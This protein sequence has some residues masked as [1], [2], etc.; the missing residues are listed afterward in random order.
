MNKTFRWLLPLVLSLGIL[1][2]PAHAA[3]PDPEVLRLREQ[4]WRAWFAGDEAALLA[5]L[6]ADFLGLDMSGT[7]LVDRATAIAAARAF[8]AGGGRLVSLEFP[9][10]QQ[11][12]YGDVVVFYGRFR[13]VMVP[14]GTATER[15][16]EG[17]LTE[18]FRFADG[19]WVHPGWHLDTVAEPRQP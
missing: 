2:S 15:T 8:A 16:I 10:T 9:E 18:V 5:I 13:V 19:R 3:S 1:P 14:P 17:R 7:E 11:Q 12:R 4:A 6:P